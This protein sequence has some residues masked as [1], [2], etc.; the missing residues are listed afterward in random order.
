MD[1]VFTIVPHKLLLFDAPS[2]RLPGPTGHRSADVDGRQRF[3]AGFV[4]DL[5]HGLGVTLVL[6]LD[7]I[8][9][10][11][12]PFAARGIRVCSSN[13]IL[14][15]AMI[16]ANPADDKSGAPLLVE[17]LARFVALAKST[18]GAVAM[19]G[20]GRRLRLACTLA[21]AG[22]ADVRLFPSPQAAAAWVAIVRGAGTSIDMAALRAHWAR[23]AGW[24]GPSEPAPR[25]PRAPAGTTPRA[26][27]AG[28][29]RVGRVGAGSAGGPRS[30][31][32]RGGAAVRLWGCRV[33][34]CGKIQLSCR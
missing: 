7:N 23:R 5:L 22:L 30:A 25:P 4:A 21:A 18:P 8:D 20:E 27:L 1:S 24:T 28:G 32:R 16:A 2:Q 10:D 6:G 26:R 29:L 14:L 34:S 17:M 9:Y 12:A 31:G 33:R 15:S 19:H 11:P 13:D 3:S